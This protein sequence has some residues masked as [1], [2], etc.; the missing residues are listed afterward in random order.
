M[1]SAG[2]A[3]AAEQRPEESLGSILTMEAALDFEVIRRVLA[4]FEREGVRYAVFG[5]AALNL[6]G[7]ARFTEDLDVFLA[8]EAENIERVKR[9][10]RSVFD[11][12]EIEGISA[13]D[14]LGDYP[15]V[16]YV[17]PTGSFHVD[18]LTRLGE[19]FA[20]VDL[21]V[22]RVLFEGLHVSVVTPATLYRMKR[23]TVRIKD[24]ADAELLK[25][26]FDLPEED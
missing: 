14:L 17:P 18:L 10:L 7:L 4:A 26:R 20:F 5:A 12:P 6:H 11:D 2:S 16:Q 24:R 19:A 1:S 3:N 25:Q 8:P 13:K 21:Q 22:E 23:D 15:A 9:A